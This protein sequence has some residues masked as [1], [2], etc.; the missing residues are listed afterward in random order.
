MVSRSRVLARRRAAAIASDRSPA[1][2]VGPDDSGTTLGGLR[3][4]LTD[5]QREMLRR[6][7]IGRDHLGWV[8]ARTLFH[9]LPVSAA[10]K[11][12]ES[13]GGSVL[14][15]TQGGMEES[16]ALTRLGALLG[17]HGP[18]FEQL[19]AR[20]LAYEVE[21]YDADSNVEEIAHAEVQRDLKLSESELTDLFRLITMSPSFDNGSA[22]GQLWKV[23]V[24][25]N[26][27][28][29][30]EVRDWPRYVRENALKDYD[31]A[32]PVRAVAR[33]EYDARRRGAEVEEADLP[34]FWRPGHFRLFISHLSEYKILASTLSEALL[35][36][37][38][39]AFVA[40]E[41]IQPTKA[42]ENEIV[43][44]LGS[45]QALV[46][47]LAPGFRSSPWTDQ[48]VGFVMGRGKLVIPVMLDGEPPY[49]FMARIQGL[50][51]G[52]MLGEQLASLLFASLARNEL[53]RREL[54]TAI[55]TRVENSGS[56]SEAVANVVLL[57]ELGHID[58]DLEA[59]VASA[60][61][62]N[63]AMRDIALLHNRADVA[64]GL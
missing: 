41:H 51:G 36:H 42:W 57:G 15:E 62:T 9:R 33:E 1:L 47:L 34:A 35:K 40:H 26:V 29:L 63:K 45:A 31:P 54:A 27:H 50:K 64:N 10:R 43:S 49:G 25:K 11:T 7:W 14:K 18:E 8:T 19:L 20:Y 30:T 46:A 53:T 12:L 38:I 56:V 58:A 59:R 61:I 3:D 21:R 4:H 22:G 13:L 48:E 32:L 55:I 24:M 23:R 16:Y 60:R 28:D 17:E 39:S 52:G 5:A 2:P 44:A 6:L 37:H